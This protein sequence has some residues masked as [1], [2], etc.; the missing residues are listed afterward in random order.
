MLPSLLLSSLVKQAIVEREGDKWVLWTKD[1]SRRLGTHDSARQAYAQEYA[2]EKSEER[3]DKQATILRRL[4]KVATVAPVTLG[5]PVEVAPAK[6]APV[7]IVPP[8][9]A[10]TDVPEA[11]PL[12]AVPAP[13]KASSALAVSL[14]LAAE[15]PL[16][17]DSHGVARANP[18]FTPPAPGEPGGPPEPGLMDGG[19]KGLGG[20][21]THGLGHAALNVPL[22][23]AGWMSPRNMTDAAAW[24]GGKAQ[25][26]WHNRDYHWDRSKPYEHY[27]P[28]AAVPD[29]KRTGFAGGL[30]DSAE[31]MYNKVRNSWNMGLAPT[32]QSADQLTPK[33]HLGGWSQG[34]GDNPYDATGR[35][36][37]QPANA[38]GDL[39]AKPT[40]GP[41][42]APMVQ[43]RPPTS[44]DYATQTI[45]GG[46]QIAAAPPPPQPMGPPAT[47]KV[48][49]PPTPHVPYVTSPQTPLTPQTQKPGLPKPLVPKMPPMFG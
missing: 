41:R 46:N 30:L 19:I 20:K 2:I 16:I 4:I 7:K 26:W 32:V 6:Q 49:T 14:K 3:R 10:S 12:N 21:L 23:F 29:Q 39:P 11:K 35:R 13:F 37:D 9:N 48:S 36:L 15:E 5:K 28:A 43:Y 17:L 34:G 38:L 42:S 1:R 25:D 18:R 45:P 22:P 44:Q 24:I 47:A 27:T 8:V 40:A 31:G 33:D